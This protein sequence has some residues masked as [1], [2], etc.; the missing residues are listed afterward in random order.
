MKDPAD[1][2]PKSRAIT[3]MWYIIIG[4][5]VSLTAL[6]NLKFGLTIP[7]RGRPMPQDMV[8]GLGGIVIIMGI[9]Q[10]VIAL[11]VKLGRNR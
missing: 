2:S 10:L 9:V 3:G 1:K 11:I 5:A 7:Y 6:A 8:A 4:A